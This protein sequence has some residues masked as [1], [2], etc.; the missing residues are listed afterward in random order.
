MSLCHTHSQG[1]AN[2]GKGNTSSSS[3][4]IHFYTK[5]IELMEQFGHFGHVLLLP[6][7]SD[8]NQHQSAVVYRTGGKY[9]E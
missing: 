4:V 9:L 2:Q 3:M 1:S 8:E 5:Y 6:S 7:P